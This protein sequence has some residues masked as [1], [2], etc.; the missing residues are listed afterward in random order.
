MCV[1]VIH[2][3]YF[4]HKFDNHASVVFCNG[5][6]NLVFGPPA[7]LHTFLRVRT[8]KDINGRLHGG[9]FSLPKRQ[10][11]QRF[12]VFRSLL[13]LDIVD[14]KNNTDMTVVQKFIGKCYKTD[15]A[16][17][18]ST[19]SDTTSTVDFIRMR[20]PASPIDV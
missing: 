9:T 16:S 18:G 20:A 3:D 12:H 17:A 15:A 6:N 13:R 2:S 8:K 5:F 11:P 14:K 10:S 7:F 19:C 1:F 4:V